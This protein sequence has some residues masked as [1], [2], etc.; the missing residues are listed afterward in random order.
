MIAFK[1]LDETTSALLMYMCILF[2]SST[3][4]LSPS[5][6]LPGSQ[7]LLGTVHL[8]LLL[9]WNASKHSYWGRLEVRRRG[10]RGEERGE[11]EG[12]GGGRRE[13]NRNRRGEEEGGEEEGVGEE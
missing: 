10:E 13:K 3:Q 5:L 12:K 11:K 9:L 8:T 1:S 7:L 2:L 6:L 4:S